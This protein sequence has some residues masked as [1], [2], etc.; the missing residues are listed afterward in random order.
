MSAILHTLTEEPTTETPLFD[1]DFS[2]A[3]PVPEAIRRHHRMRDFR[4]SLDKDGCVPNLGHRSM[5]EF[6]FVQLN[7]D[8]FIN[9]L[10]VDVDHDN[11]ELRLLH[12]SVP[13]PH[14]IIINPDNGHGQAGWMIEPVYRGPKARPRPIEYARAVQTSLD[15]ATDCDEAFTR[16]LVRNPVAHSPA[17]IVRF[18]SRPSPYPLGELMKHMQ[19]YSD[20]FEPDYQ[21][22]NPYHSFS[23]RS[24]AIMG[25]AETGN[26]NN[27]LFRATRSFLYDRWAQDHLDP[28]YEV[29]YNHA[30]GLNQRLDTPLAAQEVRWLSQSAVRQVQKGRGRRAGNNTDEAY[31]EHCRRVGASGGRVKSPRKAAAARLNAPKA[32]QARRQATDDLAGQAHDLKAQGASLK[33]I[34]EALNR[35]VATVRRWFRERL[36]GTPKKVCKSQATGNRVSALP[37]ATSSEATPKLVWSKRVHKPG[38][39]LKRPPALPP[40]SL[41]LPNPPSAPGEPSLTLHTE[42][43]LVLYTSAMQ[44][45]S[46]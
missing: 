44:R 8:D 20:P 41:P 32:V 15:L 23:G 33:Q 19:D 46:T 7:H 42:L 4:V 14:W 43:P 12:P 17:G 28:T 10:V 6:P 13:E 1:G 27:S 37:R 30:M 9:F 36:L 21:A 22:W 34:A 40:T 31:R 45:A 26:R 5:V 11:A 38:F 35:S 2:T 3:L 24:R 25:E 18:G 16:Y 39:P 29:A